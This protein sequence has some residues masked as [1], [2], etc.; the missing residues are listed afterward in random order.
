MT[1]LEFVEVA[2]STVCDF[3]FLFALV[4]GNEP[5]QSAI[6]NALQGDEGGG[7]RGREGGGFYG[8]VLG[9]GV[10]DDERHAAA[11]LRAL[12]ALLIS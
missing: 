5:F 7:P 1:D 4:L 10:I 11:R 8:D 12:A 6:A 2:A 9:D 3:D